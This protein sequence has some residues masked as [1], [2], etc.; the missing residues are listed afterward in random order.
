MA[1]FA[2]ASLLI[3]IPLQFYYAFTNL[4]LNQSGVRDAAGKMT[5]GQISELLLHAADP[6]VLSPP[7]RQIHAGHRHVCVGRAIRVVRLRK[8]W[9]QGLDAVARDTGAWSL[10]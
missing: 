6:L 4:Y 8:R 7:G 5:G 2:I 9:S 1:V 10:L 3:C